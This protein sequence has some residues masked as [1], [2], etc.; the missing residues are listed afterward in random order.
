MTRNKITTP[1]ILHIVTVAPTWKLFRGQLGYLKKKG[2]DFIMVSSP[3]ELLKSYAEQES[4]EYKAI[5]IERNIS[6]FKDIVSLCRVFFYVY[7]VKPDIVHSHTA[8]GGMIGMISAWLAGVKCRIYHLRGLRYVTTNGV[9]R[10]V[11]MFA[12]WIACKLA[13]KVICVSHS[14]RHIAIEDNICPPHKI[15]VIAHGSSNGVDAL[16]KYNPEILDKHDVSGFRKK[17]NLP[18]NVFVIGFVGRIVVDKGIIDLIEAWQQIRKYVDDIHLM[19]VGPIESGDKVPDKYID[20]LKSDD[21]I[22]VVGDVE[23]PELC[24]ANLDVLVL[25]TYRE[26]FANA[27]LE[28]MAMSLPIVATKVTGCIDPVVDGETGVLV[29]VKS[30][31]Q[32][33]NAVKYLYENK[34]HA[35]VMGKKGRLRALEKYKPETVWDGYYQEYMKLLAT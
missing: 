34:E 18:D 29:D 11:L 23:S 14:V 10:R 32:I 15:T 7:Q 17:I 8:K 2:L 24:Y 28:G 5:P 1:K 19:I 16:N 20:I 22:H 31:N 3:G 25:P 21:R 26:G 12:E 13:N 30:P 9:K 35:R 27:I 6:L 4:F 33:V